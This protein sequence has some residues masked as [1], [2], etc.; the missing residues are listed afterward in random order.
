[1][2]VG[3][4]DTSAHVRAHPS[5]STTPH[6]R[7]CQL[8]SLS[9]QGQRARFDP[10]LVLVAVCQWSPSVSTQSTR[11]CCRCSSLSLGMPTT[12]SKSNAAVL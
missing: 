6:A 7:R 5:T 12:R 9:E 2:R 1:M 10:R 8:R 4:A 3:G 11:C